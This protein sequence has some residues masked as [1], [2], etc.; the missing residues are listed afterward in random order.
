MWLNHL[1]Y[2]CDLDRKMNGNRLGFHGE[3]INERPYLWL[4]WTS[5]KG[6][7]YQAKSLEWTL[8]PQKKH[9]QDKWRVHHFAPKHA[10]AYQQFTNGKHALLDSSLSPLEQESGGKAMMFILDLKLMS[11]MTWWAN[12][13]IIALKKELQNY[14][15]RCHF[16][17]LLHTRSLPDR[18]EEMKIQRAKN[19]YICGIKK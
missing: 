17:F 7:A 11:L 15:K 12:E 1:P 14:C 9:C 16:P 5:L 6:A 19:T 18:G 4:Y 3:K 10:C 2:N 13:I 8:S